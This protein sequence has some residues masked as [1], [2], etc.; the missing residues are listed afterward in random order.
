MSV[1]DYLRFVFPVA[2]ILLIAAEMLHGRLRRRR[3]Y[4]WRETGTSLLLALGNRVLNATLGGIAA[5]PLV[6]AAGLSPLRIEMTGPWAW[7]GLFLGLE[8][9]YYLHH[10]AMHRV[11]WFWA[12]HLVHHSATLFNLSA[13]IR[14][15]WGGNVLGASL[16]YLPLA[17]IGFPPIAIGVMFALNLAYQFFLHFAAAPQLGPLEWVLNTP[18]H[19]RVHH[20]SNDAC[21][22]RNFGGVLIVFDRLFGTF[23]EAP[24]EEALRFGLKGQQVRADKPFVILLHGWRVML[25]DWRAAGSWGGRWRA[26]FGAP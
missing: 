13:A 24:K 14:L 18:T 26:L 25:A 2:T 21:L 22:D 4:D 10:Y 12:T 9:C 7:L 15:G 19:H 17:L 5:L 20:A 8:F 16:F 1:A 23:A 6:W 3:V 11:R